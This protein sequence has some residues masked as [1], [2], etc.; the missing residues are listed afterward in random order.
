MNDLSDNSEENKTKPITVQ[1]ESTG[2]IPG[3]A[4]PAVTTPAEHRADKKG[5]FKKT[6]LTA[7]LIFLIPLCSALIFAFFAR[8][9]SPANTRRNDKN[10]THSETAEGTPP[11]PAPEAEPEELLE[12]RETLRQ[13]GKPVKYAN[14]RIWAVAGK[15][16]ALLFEIPS[17][18][19]KKQWKWRISQCGRYALAI[20]K[21]EEEPLFRETALYSLCTEEWL[22]QKRLP[23]PMQYE[24]PWI[25][26][27]HLILRSWKNNRRFAMELDERGEILSLDALGE[28]GAF[29]KKNQTPP[30]LHL[31]HI[32]AIRAGVIFTWDPDESTLKGF[33]PKQLPGLHRLK[34]SPDISCI[35]GN[36]LLEFSAKDGILSAFDTFTGHPL[37]HQK[38]WHHSTN[39]TVRGIETN[40]D[41]SSVRIYAESSFTDKKTT[42]RKWCVN[43]TALNGAIN[44]DRTN[45]PA[46]SPR[47]QKQ[48]IDIPEYG[49]RVSHSGSKLEI[50]VAE[51]ADNTVIINFHDFP[52]L[53]DIYLTGI[54]LLEDKRYLHIHTETDSFLLDL[55]TVRHYGDMLARVMHS[56]LILAEHS[57]E[58]LMRPAPTDSSLPDIPKHSKETSDTYE[59][60]CGRD[61]S[62]GYLINPAKMEPP[63]LPSIIS[64]QA[65]LLATH[66]AWLYA[67]HKL[68]RLTTL[69][70]QDHR[71]PKANPLL[72]A[73]YA[74]LAGEE[75]M[76]RRA[77]EKGLKSLYFDKSPYNRMIRWQFTRM[78]FYNSDKS[79]D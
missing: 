69:Q 30:D 16:P 28:G 52:D 13:L 54:S 53:E 10:A 72:L 71:A 8:R 7:I 49:L 24:D 44:T 70:E 67:A 26:S 1:P 74:T 20:E 46:F 48:T 42:E 58:E 3:E 61:D 47:T 38:L 12:Y 21:A 19:P 34:S 17:P 79:D 39:T 35:T 23:W 36:G 4:E 14:L 62:K 57:R 66:R 56:R 6:V 64:I 78:L 51:S 31:K 68:D 15:H 11:A 25:F 41:G 59:V 60:N 9:I 50:S 2:K 33:S 76:A 45:P 40:R 43:Y 22:W 65:E 77:C 55:H 75:K 37:L 29:P 18:A 27:G 5:D 32:T 63:S 73:R